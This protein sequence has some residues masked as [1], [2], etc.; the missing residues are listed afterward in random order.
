MKKTLLFISIVAFLSSCAPKMYP[1][2][3]HYP[4]VTVIKSSKPVD[5]VW[6]KIIDLF[7]TRGIPIR[8]IDKSSGLISSDRA[9][10]KGKYS[11][12]NKDGKI[13]Y[14]DAWVVLNYYQSHNALNDLQPNTITAE[15]NVRIKPD[16]TGSTINVNLVNIIAELHTPAVNAGY[17]S[18]PAVDIVYDARSTGVFEQIIAD[19]VK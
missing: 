10:L 13:E 8:V 11:F 15:W 19:I 2:K 17:L 12:E 7:A 1:I 14:K 9:S 3:G 4:E 18:K 6:S 5:S 16:G